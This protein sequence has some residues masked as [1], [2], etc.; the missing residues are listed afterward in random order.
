MKCFSKTIVVIL[1]L[2]FVAIFL[3]NCK[4][5]YFYKSL[6]ADSELTSKVDMGRGVV[7]WNQLK[8]D[9]L[10]HIS[11]VASMDSAS[12]QALED[13]LLYQEFRK[14]KLMTIDELSDN[15][16]GYYDKL[17]DILLAL[18]VIFSASS[19]LVVYYNFK[20][21]FEDDKEEMMKKIAEQLSA[22][23][24]YQEKVAEALKHR[25]EDVLVKRDEVDNMAHRL[26]NNYE[27]ISFLYDMVDN[28]NE[29][30]SSKV[31]IE[32]DDD[33]YPQ[34]HD[35]EKEDDLKIVT[36]AT[37]ESGESGENSKG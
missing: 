20:K 16:T 5:P 34:E 18:F 7:R 29:I 19:Y 3:V 36:E 26:S 12:M 2:G 4:R 15:I 30:S 23:S 33:N 10:G 13:S 1:L 32:V 11:I 22:S 35:N 37:D 8:T 31:D 14:G 17:I 24:V 21:K 6:I 25:M 27:D 28:I 9:S